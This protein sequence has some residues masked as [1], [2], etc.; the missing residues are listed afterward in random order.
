MY[1]DLLI[2]GGEGDLALNKLHPA[3]Y[4]LDLAGGLRFA[5]DHF[6]KTLP[7]ATK[8]RA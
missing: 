6:S 7:A 3:L 5:R 8:N 1:C 4:R 2:V